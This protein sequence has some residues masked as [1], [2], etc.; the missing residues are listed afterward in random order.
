MLT[1]KLL[2]LIE[3]LL[4]IIILIIHFIKQYKENKKIDSVLKFFDNKID[5][6]ESEKLKQVLEQ[7]KE[8]N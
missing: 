5:K 7:N 6:S 3:L 1:F 8:E 4:L 2:V